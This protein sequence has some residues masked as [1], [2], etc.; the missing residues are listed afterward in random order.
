MSVDISTLSAAHRT[1]IFGEFT[2]DLD[3]GALL[4]AG[5]DLTLR[6]KSFEV[7]CHLVQRS[8]LLVTKAELLDA[9][10][11]R[12]IVTE[13]SVSHCVSDIRKAIGDQSQEMIRTVPRRGY[14]F[15]VPV[16]NNGELDPQPVARSERR[17]SHHWPR[18]SL[19]AL[20]LLV[21]GTAVALS[22]LR[23]R[24]AGMSP[25]AADQSA[26]DTLSIAV[27]PFSD[28][29][30]EQDQAYLAD[31]VSEDILN[32]LARVPGLR[33][34][35]R[36]S[37]FSFRDARVE[38]LTVARQLNV[39]YVLE[40]SVRAFGNQLRV[41]V[42]LID[43]RSDTSL[44][45]GTYDR[46]LGDV[47]GVQSEISASIA[48]S[49]SVELLEAGPEVRRVDSD[50]YRLA[51]KAKYFW[52]RK[53]PGDE[54]K[55]M[56]YY[57]QALDTDPGHAP[58]WAGVSALYLSQALEGRVD[59]GVPREEELARAREAARMAL[60]LD[61][62]LSDAH[63]RMGIIHMYDRNRAAAFQAY[64]RAL[65]LDPNNPLAMAAMAVVWLDGR[66][67]EGIEWYGKA[68]SVDPMTTT[69]PNN[70]AR[71]MIRAG[72]LDE[73]E[74]AARKAMEL[75]PFAFFP[76]HHLA[77]IHL[78]RGQFAEALELGEALAEQ[79]EK[80][81]LL[82]A[83]YHELGRQQEANLALQQLARSA[84]TDI[85]LMVAQAHAWC[86][87]AD[88]AFEWLNTANRTYLENSGEGLAF[89]LIRTDPFLK[90]LQDDRR[91]VAFLGRLEK[92][93]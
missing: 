34:I 19:A 92:W 69:W 72:R 51:L 86:G 28:M 18:W 89:E 88:Q 31:G 12:T 21:L 22:S 23:T 15:D 35:S 17:R 33:V 80:T 87:N 79:P 4:R 42:Q 24:D 58:A 47:L 25:A 71:L 27:L 82:A 49:L 91:W 20:V 30:P 81:R 36:S 8:G 53:L 62:E 37:A 60:S 70:M 3:R 67:D 73:A 66:L 90:G 38:I 59:A 40:G 83:V 77:L 65:A 2:L 13:D 41:T 68:A 57:R 11:G 44:W 63:V 39:D 6:P 7:L 26:A 9:V 50:A 74:E 56:H 75:S 84:G 16:G 10:W 5:V 93:N 1:Y 52:N 14:I 78:L 85:P 54:Q 61:P 48:D 32:R 29:S 55:A 64:R 45:S 43:A 76:R 46:G